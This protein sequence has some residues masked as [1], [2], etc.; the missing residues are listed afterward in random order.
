MDAIAIEWVN[1][2]T[3]WDDG[4]TQSINTTPKTFW[5]GSTAGHDNTFEAG[6]TRDAYYRLAFPSG[7]TGGSYTQDTTWTILNG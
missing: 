2:D 3:S 5:D 6:E 7:K 4:F 1:D